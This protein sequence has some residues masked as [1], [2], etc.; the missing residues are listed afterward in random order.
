ME[1]THSP[2]GPVAADP[3]RLVRSLPADPAGP[4]IAGLFAEFDAV[5]AE[6]NATHA[7]GF[8]FV[9]RQQSGM[10]R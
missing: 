9:E 10:L 3:S 8:A 1:N 2:G 7:A 4:F 6:L 5:M